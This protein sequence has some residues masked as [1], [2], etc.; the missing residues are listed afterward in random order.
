MRILDKEALD[1]SLEKPAI[2]VSSVYKICK[3]LYAI[4]IRATQQIRP[5]LQAVIRLEMPNGDIVDAPIGRTSD[6]AR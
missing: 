5:K 6:K 3:E 4:D 1:A 2:A